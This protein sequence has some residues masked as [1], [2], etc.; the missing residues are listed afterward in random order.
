MTRAVS[1]PNDDDPRYAS[2]PAVAVRRPHDFPRLPR[3][4]ASVHHAIRERI[5]TPGGFHLYGSFV[6]AAITG[7]PFRDVDIAAASRDDLE[8]LRPLHRTPCVVST[9]RGSVG[10]TIEVNEMVFSTVSQL[11]HRTDFTI[12]QAVYSYPEDRVYLASEFWE[13]LASFTLVPNPVD[14]EPTLRALMRIYKYASKGY[15]SRIDV[16]RGT[17]E[18]Y[19]RRPR[20]RTW[21]ES[22]IYLR[23]LKTGL[24]TAA[25]PEPER[26]PIDAL[27]ERASAAV[28]GS[29]SAAGTAWG[30]GA[31]GGR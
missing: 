23:G 31:G 11:L 9:T 21:A 2:L 14:D 16:L 15:R 29:W 5:G 6:R 17:L 12:T 26:E 20:W 30:Q 7:E 10:V 18:R 22:Q 8:R 25:N 3:A 19:K 1:A 27:R 24:I 13:H 28:P 4:L